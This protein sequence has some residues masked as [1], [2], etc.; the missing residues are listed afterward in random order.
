MPDL[1]FSK[2]HAH[3]AKPTSPKERGEVASSPSVPLSLCPSVPSS[4]P[5][6]PSSYA[7]L[8]VTSNFTFLSGASHPDELVAQAASLRHAAIAIT[9]LHSLAGIVRA[10]VAAKEHNIQLIVGTKIIPQPTHTNRGEA[11]PSPSVPLSLWPSVPSSCPSV[12]SLTLLPT[13]LP[14]Y[15]NLCRLLTRGKRRAEKGQCHISLHD[16]IELNAGLIAIITPPAP[17]GGVFTPDETFIDTLRDLRSVFNDDRLS[18]AAHRLYTSHDHEYLDQLQSLASHTQVP[19][20]ATNDVHYHIAERRALQDVLTCIKHTT[21]IQQAGDRL[22]PHGERYLKPPEEMHRLFAS[23]PKAIAR[24]I[25]IARR[26]AGFSLDQVK[27][28]YPEEICP[29][30]RSPMAH[31][32]ELTWKGAADRFKKPLSER[33]W[34][35]P[36]PN[37]SPSVPSGVP[38]HSV[39]DSSPFVPLSLCP[40]VPSEIPPHSVWGSSPSVPLS[41]CP[42]VPSSSPS[43]P[44]SSPSAPSSFSSQI[45]PAV[46]A[47]IEHEFAIIEDLDYAK[48]FLTV[49]DIVAFARSRGILCQ[50]RGA[51]ANSAVCYCLGITSVDPSRIDLL[52][53]RFVSKERNE[54]PDIDIDFEHERREEVIQYIYGK[55][56]RDRAALVA[57]IISYRGRSAVREVG[58]ALGLSLDLVDTLAKELDRWSSKQHTDQDLRELGLDPRD[59]TLRLCM[60]LTRQILG[61]PRH[62]SQH[63]G[64][65]IISHQNLSDL[66]PIEN[67]AMENRTVIEWDKD[68]VDAMGMLKIDCLGLG[69]L[70]C[71]RKALDF[72]NEEG[73]KG[74]EE[75]TEGQRDK[76]TKEMNA[77]SLH[78][79]LNKKSGA[80][81]TSPSVPLSLCP[82]VPSSCPS[83]PSG[84]PPHSVWGSSPSVPLSLCPSVPLSLCPSVPSSCPSVPLSLHSIPPEDPAVYD[85]ACRADTIGVFQIES[86]AQMSMLPRLKPRRFYDLVI[87]VAIVRPG[88]IQGDMVHPYLRRRDGKEPVIFPSEAVRDVLGKTLG[89]PLFQEQAMRLA[90]VA[91]GFSAGEADKLRRAMAAWKRKGDRLMAFEERFVGG[92]LANNY[93]PDF[94]RRC[95]EQLKGF[96]EYGFPE[97]HAASFAL[98]VYVSAW[99]KLHH[100]AAFA[101]AL[102]NSQ[103]MGFY[104][105]AQLVRDARE[106]GTTVHPID[107]NHSA[108]NCTLESHASGRP[109]LRL[110]MR[111]VRSLSEPHADA[112]SHA[113][114]RRGPFS[115]IE[116]LWRASRVPLAALRALARADAFRSMNVDRRQALWQIQDLRDNPLPLF[117]DLVSAPDSSTSLLPIMP[118]DRQVLHDYNAIGLSLKAHPISFFRD[119]LASLR[120]TTSSHIRDK[121]RAGASVRIAGMVLV[122]QRPSTASGVVFITIEDETGAANL[123]LR[124][125]VYERFRRAAKLSSCVAVKG[126]VERQGSVVHV[127]VSKIADLRKVLVSL[128]SIP[129]NSRDFY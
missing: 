114:A 102:I 124:P 112:I 97:S 99:I 13:S 77:A 9:D 84:V 90:I 32:R 122:R 28:E 110:G 116:S 109:A 11:A 93:P 3:P 24:T 80:A 104:A 92:M 115:S 118:P 74:L 4:S 76:E 63:V 27:Y 15:T 7:D 85:M 34:F 49:Y 58:K 89:V 2:Y 129:S 20:V 83:V 59:H 123:I 121:A 51:A 68:D 86:R 53:E 29:K 48:Y 36:A 45:P 95:F 66:V 14:A 82:S 125:A 18:L 40:S 71:I 111:L 72:I 113:V 5:F 56:G 31:L 65:F 6:V 39:W 107:V 87:Q 10:H 100:P 64:G 88:P 17:H 37:S 30:G 23:H 117:D 106:H 33:T 103:P 38:P 25:D 128:P 70:T 78:D 46:L 57:E 43:V 8:Q 79:S 60:N 69:M 26:C 35:E 126:T 108:W 50:G 52:F 98:L 120:F 75:G 16:I 61:F 42:S 47:R 67:A 127:M 62:L 119:R 81:A 21:T 41:L 55:Y 94:A 101:A 91:A 96:S 54:P 19:L 1:P 44:S 22:F 105:P 12:P 73:T